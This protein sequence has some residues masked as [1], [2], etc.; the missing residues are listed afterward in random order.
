[1]SA[2]GPPPGARR[3]DPGQL[4]ALLERLRTAALQR[5]FSPH[6]VR[7]YDGW[8]RRFVVFHR[9]CDPSELD[10]ADLRRFLDHATLRGRVSAS[11]RNQALNALV[12]LYR[13]VLGREPSPAPGPPLR[14]KPSSRVPLVL[15]PPE[16]EAILKQLRGPCRLM[17]AILYGSGLRVSECCRLRVRD[18]DFARD[19][20]TVHDGKGLKDRVTLLP[21]RIKQALRDHLDG[22]GY[23]HQADLARGGGRVPI[24]GNV[25]L[26]GSTAPR[27]S[28]E[29]PWQWVFPTAVARLDRATGELVRN[30]IHERVV[31]R[32]FAIAVRAAGIRKPATCHSLR[33]SFATQLHET[34]HDLRTIQKL[35]GHNDIA[36]TLLYTR[37]SRGPARPVR[38]PLD[39]AS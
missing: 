1:V 20:L 37:F 39:G 3:L 33:H 5:G 15:A 23:L 4:A 26:A 8:V 28:S 7:A 35:L 30:H 32:E 9:Q 12:F 38:S 22:V 17:V 19:T 6:T 11:T 2:S 14:A 10:A 24:P 18:V 36:T 34:G 31:Q 29:W 13:D 25:S 16:V 21:A 27:A